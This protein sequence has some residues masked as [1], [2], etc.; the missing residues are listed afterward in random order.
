VPNAD[1][2]RRG[3]EEPR[4]ERARQPVE[5]IISP[6]V[7]GVSAWKEAL[8]GID[9][10]GRIT[11]ARSRSE[12]LAALLLGHAMFF[13]TPA[14]FGFTARRTHRTGPRVPAPRARRGSVW[15]HTASPVHPDPKKQAWHAA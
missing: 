12:D 14:K 4:F 3:R 1:Q 5:K 6:G 7:L 15:R 13:G 9:F 8:W 10:V 11:D 2:D